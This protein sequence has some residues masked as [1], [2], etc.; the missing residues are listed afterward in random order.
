MVDSHGTTEMIGQ[1]LGLNG[2]IGVEA[3]LGR[4]KKN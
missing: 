1:A 2:P 4:Q 3:A